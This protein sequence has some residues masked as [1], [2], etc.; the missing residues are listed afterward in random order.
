MVHLRLGIYTHQSLP[1]YKNIFEPSV[2]RRNVL[3]SNCETIF[4]VVMFPDRQEF[5][6]CGRA[7]EERSSVMKK[8]EPEVISF[9]VELSKN[10]I[11]FF[12]QVFWKQDA[13]IS[14]RS[15]FFPMFHWTSQSILSQAFLLTQSVLIFVLKHTRCF[16]SSKFQIKNPVYKIDC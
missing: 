8:E 2:R 16:S 1:L 6:F 9:L 15:H 13:K 14:L 4:R 11:F 5:R 7:Y 3:S 12:A 10:L